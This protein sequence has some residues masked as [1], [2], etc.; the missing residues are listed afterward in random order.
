VKFFPVPFTLLAAA[1]YASSADPALMLSGSDAE[2]IRRAVAQHAD[3]ASGPAGRLR[4]EAG[5]CLK[6]GPWSVTYER[7]KGLAIDSHDYYSEGTYW[8]PDPANPNGPYIRKDGHT[9]PGRFMANKSAL[10]AMSEAV[11]TLGTAAY[12]FDDARYAERAVQVMRVW[13]IDPATRMNPHLEY[14]QAV[15][16]INSGRGAGIIDT[17]VL[18]RA[19]QGIELLD[20]TGRLDAETRE[21]V[22]RWYADF[23]KWLTTSKK[24]LDEKKSG[25]NHASWWTAQAA[26]F[27]D[28]TGDRETQHM[29]FTWLRDELFPKQIRPDGSA[30]REEARTKAL[31]Y[32]AFNLDAYSITC[33]IAHAHGVDLWHMQGHGGVTIQ[34]V[35]GYL[36]PSLQDPSKWK[37]DQIVTFDNSG[38]SYLAFAGIGLNRPDYVKI[39]RQYEKPSGAWLALVDL[40]TG[41]IN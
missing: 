36:L 24:G 38:M 14:G 31:G 13:F 22:K 11:F 23:L 32:S 1:A 19:A 26:A 41:S 4:A 39:Y 27:A 17:R 18:I 29:A 34:S 21:G 20:R 37:R 25:N 6:E 15:R 9:Y 28:L 5:R 8:W 35:I 7:P 2:Q 33:R 12:L 40:I 10:N 3:W 16:G 30:P